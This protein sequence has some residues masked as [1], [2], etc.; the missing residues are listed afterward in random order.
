[1]LGTAKPASVIFFGTKGEAGTLS[2]LSTEINL[3]FKNKGSQMEQGKTHIR[4]GR[5]LGKGQ[6]G[7]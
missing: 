6:Y 7:K 1:M 3:P 2:Y 4:G 5:K